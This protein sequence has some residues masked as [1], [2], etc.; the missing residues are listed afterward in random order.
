RRA[1]ST[2]STTSATARIASSAHTHAGVSLTDEPELDVVV[3][4][5][6]TMI[7]RVV[8]CSSV[9]VV[10]TVVGSVV[11]AVVVVSTVVVSA[12]R[13]FPTTVARRIPAT[14]QAASPATCND[15]LT[16]RGYVPRVVPSITRPG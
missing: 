2:I 9:A 11:V 5:V 8:V 15:L 13:T 16:R 14:R 7:L 1:S 4:D 6:V 3:G 10:I 12:A